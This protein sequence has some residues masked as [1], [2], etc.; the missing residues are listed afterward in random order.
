MTEEQES[1][2]KYECIKEFEIEL[3]DENENRTNECKTIQVG[4]KWH[5]SYECASSV[6]LSKTNDGINYTWVDIDRDE[7]NELFRPIN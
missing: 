2:Q 3:C 1:E 7:F 5:I 4:G 6:R